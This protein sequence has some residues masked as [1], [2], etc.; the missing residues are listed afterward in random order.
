MILGNLPSLM[1]EKG[2]PVTASVDEIVAQNYL[3]PH[4]HLY[5]LIYISFIYIWLSLPKRTFRGQ[6]VC[7]SLCEGYNQS[8]QI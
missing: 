7:L 5:P 3:E 4:H 1:G 6:I 8:T 2:Q